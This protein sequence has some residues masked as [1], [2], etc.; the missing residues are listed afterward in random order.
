MFL[1]A[2]SSIRKFAVTILTLLFVFSISTP[3]PA[4]AIANILSAI[5][6]QKGMCFV[7]WD[8]NNFASSLSDKAIDLLSSSGVEYLQINTTWYQDKYDSTKIKVANNTPSDK[9]LKHAIKKAHKLGMKV[10]LKPHIDL[11][12]S[13]GGFWRADIGFQKEEDWK[14]WFASYKKFIVHYAKIAKQEDVGLFCV[15]TELSFTTQKT[16]YWNEIIE[17]V[18]TVY[19]GEIVYAANWDNFENIYFW[20]KLDYAGIDAY[21]PLTYSKSP[22][23]EE[24]KNGWNKW[25]A[26]IESW[27]NITQKPV[28]FTEIGYSSTPSAAREP[29]AGGERGNADL[30]IQ[31]KCYRA[32]FE[33]VWEKKWLVG[34]YWWRFGPTIYGGG[35]NNRRFTPLNKPAF[36]VLEENYKYNKTQ[37]SKFETVDSLK[38]SKKTLNRR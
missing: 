10:M 31:E 34:V 28:I 20:D 13:N 16:E 38:M 32:F 37:T 19:K 14:T 8:K 35:K 1:G 6:L 3:E 29:W 5:P 17:A 23:I 11:L 4:T 27:Y 25:S 26:R 7:T 12:N 18:R 30:K 33:S 9:S 22:S 24:L 15:G 21:F 2:S 36:K